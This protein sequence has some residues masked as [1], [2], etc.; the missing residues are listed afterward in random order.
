MVEGL[1]SIVDYLGNRRRNLKQIWQEKTSGAR[2][3]FVLWTV[4]FLYVRTFYTIDDS[5]DRK[6]IRLSPST[7]SEQFT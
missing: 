3:R 1:V 5:K 7:Q 6:I 4:V 2:K